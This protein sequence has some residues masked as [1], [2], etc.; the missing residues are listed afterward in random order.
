MRRRPFISGLAGLAALSR[1]LSAA[2][3]ASPVIRIELAP[4]APETSFA[5]FF[6]DQAAVRYPV[7]LG[8]SGVTPAGER[9]R[10]GYSLL[11]EFRVTGI[12]SA[13]RFEL[14][15]ELITQSGKTESWL[16]ENLF[17]NMSSIDFDGDGKGGEYGQAF[18]GLHPVDSSVPQP[19][20]FG[21]YKGVFRWYS[22]AIH[23]TQNQARIGKCITGG[24]INL[25]QADLQTIVDRVNLGDRVSITE[26]K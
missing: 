22:Y 23:G 2:E 7:G 20:H 18:I 21:T 1:G 8:R 6:D 5:E 12:L 11:G 9:F 4:D 14:E 3:K 16:R 25:G 24:C 13:S 19:F 17:R 26:R 10:G 15:P